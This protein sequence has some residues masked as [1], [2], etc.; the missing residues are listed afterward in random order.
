MTDT[1]NGDDECRA[2]FEAWI[3]LV[4]EFD[5][6]FLRRRDRSDGSYIMQ[7]VELSWQAWRECWDRRPAPQAQQVEAPTGQPAKAW[8]EEEKQ[9][10]T[11]ALERVVEAEAQPDVTLTDE[12]KTVKPVAWISRESL[13]RLC[14]GGND[15]RGTVPVHA[16]RSRTSSAPLYTAEAIAAARAEERERCA[17][18]CTEVITMYTNAREPCE[19]AEMCRDAIK[20]LAAE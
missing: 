13:S 4:P 15:S 7:S 2:E 8:T 5:S 11:S 1:T 10:L 12:G 9:A 17:E 6:K 18:I 3:S 19:S 16:K 20:A 14:S